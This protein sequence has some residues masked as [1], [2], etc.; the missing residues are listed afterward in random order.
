MNGERPGS[1]ID[2]ESASQER[3]L[4][5]LGLPQG[6][7]SD[8]VQAT[9]DRLIGFL[10]TAPLVLQPWAR[11]QADA[12]KAARTALLEGDTPGPDD[13]DSGTPRTTGTTGTPGTPGTP[14]AAGTP[15]FGGQVLPAAHFDD[16]V[17]V[18]A[19]CR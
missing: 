7:S 5:W 13:S 1:T 3:L 18:R 17:S 6:A 11:G 15:A 16:D 14:A 10:D 19:A 8:D 4:A 9:H 12:A 2:I